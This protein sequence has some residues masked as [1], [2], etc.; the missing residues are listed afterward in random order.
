M[1]R[2]IPLLII[3]CFFISCKLYSQDKPNEDVN[4]YKETT[5]YDTIPIIYRGHIYIKG[6]VDSVKAS[7][8]FD[9]GADGLGFDSLFYRK[10]SMKHY[11]IIDAFLPGA[12][13]KPQKIKLI[14]DTVNFQFA[15]HLYK[16]N[17]IPVFSLK[18]ILGDF[19]DGL[20]GRNYFNKS[21]LEISYQYQY[22]KIHDNINLI[23][24]SKYK[25]I[26]CK[27]IKNRLFMPLKLKINDSIEIKGSFMLD[28]GSGNGISLT[29]PC[30]KQF[31]LLNKIRQKVK[32][33]SK[34]G[35]IGGKTVNYTAR[36]VSLNFGGYIFNNLPIDFSIDKSGA[37][38]SNKYEGIIGNDIL[39]RFDIIIDFI[40][41]SLYI[42]PNS[43]FNKYFES[44]RIGFSFVDRTQSLSAWIVTGLYEG[45]EAEKNGIQIDDKITHIN[46][47]PILN[48]SY[49]QQR[50]IIKESNEIIL[51][52]NRNNQ[53]LF[54]KLKLKE[55]I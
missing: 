50:K 18:T 46:G 21:F 7:F 2:L 27:N 45:S 4:H 19:A 3:I 24:I 38:A 29:S 23:D 1:Y 40:N 9:T 47:E 31:S 53:K 49:E 37:L 42:K 20:I 30:A 33:Y 34:Y 52:I 44:S 41:S 32:F 15:K 51:T 12:G 5:I 22:I 55:Q 14:L 11:K 10:S 13:E 54:F 16:S 39:E 8:V 35:G 6:I 43:N 48:I 36:A 17:F 25:K 28:I 26:E